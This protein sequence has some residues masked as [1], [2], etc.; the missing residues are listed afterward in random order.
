[1]AEQTLKIL[2]DQGWNITK[3]GY[4]LITESC[5]KNDPKTVTQLLLDADIKDYGKA[6]L[7]AALNN[8]EISKVVLQIQKI[9]NISAPKSNQDSQAAPR[10]LKLILTDGH[11]HCQAIEIGILSFLN[12]NKTPPGSKLLI[13]KAN[14]NSG[15]IF[16]DD[17][18]CVLLGG[19][20]PSLY[21]K[22]EINKTI[23]KH[24]RTTYDGEGPPP[25]VSFGQKIQSSINVE[26]SFK[27]LDNSKQ[28]SK[29]SSE[30]DAQRQDAIA[31]ASSGAIR[32]VFGGGV[33]QIQNANQMREKKPYNYKE[34]VKEKRV[35]K[36]LQKEEKLQTKP[37]EKVSLFD[38]LENKLP[39]NEELPASNVMSSEVVG[40]KNNYIQSNEKPRYNQPKNTYP[41]Q[42]NS[43]NWQQRNS[44]SQANYYQENS[45][46]NYYQSNRRNQY[47][48]NNQS[49]NNYSSNPRYQ[50]YSKPN[51]PQY[52]TNRTNE[53]NINSLTENFQQISVNNNDNN[54]TKPKQYEKVQNQSTNKPMNEKAPAERNINVNSEFASRSFRMHLNI[55]S[56]SPRRSHNV[57]NAP[58]VK[59]NRKTQTSDEAAE[60]Q[61]QESQGN[62][63]GSS[64]NWKIG[65]QCMAK[66]WEDNK[67]YRATITALTNRTCVV[68]FND[69]GNFEE[70]L[71]VDCLPLQSEQ[72]NFGKRQ[73]TGTME[74]RRGG[75]RPYTNKNFN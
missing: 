50:Q 73:S 14:I 6:V 69:Y 5:A 27:S 47:N 35:K 22:W 42:A 10:M 54:Q 12:H 20:V 7:S 15:Y 1:M 72:N 28:K 66:Y 51:P 57:E 67:F 21:E 75:N 11:N 23:A 60:R 49:V 44:Y 41:V 3:D 45:Y 52:S 65:D 26:Q 16:L 39:T 32:K 64:I 18:S 19:K 68:Q 62:T 46:G 74:F 37:P 56:D 31:E 43:N 2:S 13:K 70:V 36:E 29:E 55:K 59:E 30:F 9:K 25:W 71:N 58:Q 4:D 63:S 17:N 8:S 53:K 61:D 40:N 24:T 48:Y 38:F 33:R 34:K